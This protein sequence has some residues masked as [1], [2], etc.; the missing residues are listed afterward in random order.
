MNHIYKVVFC[1]TTGTF[2]AVA[3]YARAHGKKGSGSV[4]SASSASD[5][6]A[7]TGKY[8]MFSA[9]SSAML[10]LSGNVLAAT[11]TQTST[12]TA[13]TPP[14]TGTNAC[15]YEVS[16][17]A[18]VCGDVNTT[19]TATNGSNTI[20]L[21]TSASSSNTNDIAI[22][23]GAGKNF[24]DQGTNYGGTGNFTF[25]SNGVTQPN[26][27]SPSFATNTNVSIGS[28][29][30]TN[31][32]GQ[33]NVAIGNNASNQYYG[34][35]SIT[36]GTNANN[37]S[38][39]GMADGSGIAAGSVVRARRTV[40][41]GVNA[42]TY[43]EDSIA[44]GNA[45]KTVGVDSIA[46]GRGAKA[47]ITYPSTST[48][49]EQGAIA[50]G[51]GSNAPHNQDISIGQGAGNSIAQNYTGTQ[52]LAQNINIGQGSGDGSFTND[53][54]V[55]GNSSGRNVGRS[56]KRQQDNAV[57]GSGS[58]NNV[59]GDTNTVIGWQSGNNIGSNSNVGIGPRAGNNI[60]GAN[61]VAM[62][63][64]SGNFVSGG[65]NISLGAGSGNY[66]GVNDNATSY[67][68]TTNTFG[69]TGVR[70]TESNG[71]IAAGNSA[72]R[73]V[74][75]SSNFAFGETAGNYVNYDPSTKALTSK[76]GNMA[77]GQNAGSYINGSNNI[78]MG[79]N[80]GKGTASTAGVLVRDSS[81]NFGTSA[82]A[83]SNDS[84][85]MGTNSIAGVLNTTS[86]KNGIAIGNG[87]QAIGNQAISIGTG[88]VVR[89]TNSGAIGD[90]TTIDATGVTGSAVDG[91]YSIG[92]N[93]YIN[94][95]NTFILGNNVNK[96]GTNNLP[97][98]ANSVYLGNGSNVKD[99]TSVGQVI[100]STTALNNNTST[101]TAGTTTTGGANGSVS[102]AT[103]NSGNTSVTYGTFAG[104]LSNG[105]VS[106]GAAGTERRIQNVAAGQIAANSTDAING[107]Q[108]YAV[109]QKSTDNANQV[110][111]TY[112]H[113]GEG[114]GGGDAISNLGAITDAAGATGSDSVA[115]GKQAKASARATVAVGYGANAAQDYALANGYGAQAAGLASTAIGAF[116]SATELGSIA[117]G[118]SSSATAENA[119]ALGRSSNA[120]IA[121]SVALGSDSVT[122]DPV[123]TSS[124]T[125]NGI[126]Y[127]G[128]AGSTP[129]SVVSIG[130]AGTER[131]LQNVAA[132]QI[133]ATSTDAI[134]G[135][136]LYMT[137]NVVGN[138]ASSTA[139][140]LGGNAAVDNAGNITMTD[141]G[142]TGKN[143]V[144]DAI[145]ANTAQINNTYFH[146]NT[147]GYNSINGTT[148]GGNVGT[149]NATTNLGAITDAA[150]ATQGGAVTAGINA[151]ATSAFGVAIGN[152]TNADGTGGNTNNG[153][154]IA[155]GNGA[156]ATGDVA[157][158]A[159]GV[160]A[161]ANGHQATA[162]GLQSNAVGSFTTAFG[163]NSN[164]NNYNA[165]AIGNYTAATG[166]DSAS[167]GSN[168]T[169]SG[170]YSTTTGNYAQA[171]GTLASA[172][173]HSA[174][175]Q[176]D[177]STATGANAQAVNAYDT[178]VG[179]NAT[180][181]GGNSTAVGNSAS[182]SGA[183][184][185]ALGSNA[186]A[187]G[188]SSNAIGNAASANADNSIAMGSSAYTGIDNAIAIGNNASAYNADGDVALGSNSTTSAVVPTTNGI[189]N[190]ITYGDFAGNAP[191][192]AVSIG[193]AG[194]ERQLQNVAAGQISATS[195]DAINGSQLYMTQ[196][197]V[198]NVANST[199]SILGGNAVVDPN[200]GNI[201][202]S[203][204]GG[205]GKDNVNDA[206]AAAR[207]T[208]QSSDNSINVTA[209]TGAAGNLAYDIKVNNQAIVEGAQ[210]PVVYTDTSGNKVIKSPNGNFYPA[211]TP[212][213]TN[214]NP[215]NGAAPVT[216]V[217]ASMN[218]PNNS[219]NTPTTLANVAGNLNG[220]APNTTAPTTVGT[221]PPTVN[222][223][224]AATVG[225]VLNAGWNLKTAD[226]G[227][228]DFV[229]PYD[230]VEFKNGTGTKVRS[231][232]TNGTANEIQF[233]INTSALNQNTD[234]SVT[235]GTTGDT[236]ATAE[237]VANAINNSGFNLTAQGEN[238]SLVKPGST[239]DMNNTDGNILITKSGANNNVTYNLA[240]TI[241]VGTTNPVTING[242]AGTVNGLTNTTFDPNNYVTGQAATEDQIA[243][244]VKNIDN[245]NTGTVTKG[246]NFNTDSNSQI[247]KDL[248]DELKI[249]GD[250]KNITTKT[251]NGNVVVSMTD[252]PKFTSVTTGNTVISDSG[253]TINNTDPSKVVSLTN[254][255]LNNGNNKIVNVANGDISNTS[256]DAVNGS[257]LYATNQ[258]IDTITNNITETIN[259]GTVYSGDTTTGATNAFTRQLGEQTNIVGGA[260]G[261]LTD[262]NIG[263]VSNGIDTLTVKLAKDINLGTD[264][265]V[266]ITNSDPTKTVSLTNTGLNNGG[267]IISNVG[268]GGTTT[269]NAANIGDVQNARTT[270]KSSDNSISVV[271]TA[272]AGSPNLS[273]DIK[274]NNQGITNGAQL[275]VVYTNTNGDKVYITGTDA[276]N[277]PIFNTKS[278][279]TGTAV[280]PAN[281]IASMQNA[282]GS[283]TNATTLTNVAPAALNQTSKD[284]VNGSQL[285][286]TNQQVANNTQNI[287]TNTQNIAANTANIAKGI[288]FGGTT[289]SN[290]YQLGDTI[291]VKG[292]SNIISTTVAGGAQLSLARDITVN[293]VTAGNTVLS[294]TGL[295]NG[296]NTIT[297]VA[298]GVNSTDAVNVG[299]LNNVKNVIGMVDGQTAPNIKVYNV[300]ERGTK[301]NVTV[302]DAINHMN[303]E[304]IQYFHTNGSNTN[305]IRG[306]GN[307]Q[308]SSAEGARS[309]AI[310]VKASVG[311]DASD[312]LA[313]GA[314][315]TV[316]DKAANAVA[317]GSGSVAKQTPA[318]LQAT[319][320][321]IPRG[322]RNGA[323]A[324]TGKDV[325]GEV[326]VG[327]TEATR[328]IT[329]LAAGAMPTDAVN[330]SQ[331]AAVDDKVNRLGYKVNDVADEA[332]AGISSAMAMAALPQAYLP[333]KSMLAGGMA[334]YNGEG[335]VAI[336]VSKLSDNGRWVIKVNGTADTKGNAG[337]AVGAG[338]HW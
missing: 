311:K 51:Q 256:T 157:P 60:N 334:T 192:S 89:A 39:N 252:T 139:K 254:A 53:N 182:A 277:N 27:A 106:V 24:K 179:N 130:A 219:T 102:S 84:I 226:K 227:D 207:T 243:Q 13:V 164:A 175:A 14:A 75:G 176:S 76:N 50:I 159:I 15:Y 25:Y 293:S 8:L 95:S 153:G 112:F 140:V 315:A 96:N 45:A 308:D 330:V 305:A 30:G 322:T 168:A 236:F 323:I 33:R 199:A 262:N 48:N 42:M 215:T 324:G 301:D 142:G 283:T 303:T 211:G 162:V 248:G 300:A 333:G 251:E 126:T 287:A 122:T 302:V 209:N 278:D 97:S 149:G 286:A 12:G 288:N 81:L 173:G 250:G 291:N 265:S 66:V 152:N 313:L 134:N 186:S 241:K 231:Q 52:P 212:L 220:A 307:T 151:Q 65:A 119:M 107:S 91:S 29:A 253:V 150:G 138:V 312:S 206:I 59:Q 216:N 181:Q 177:Y 46:I 306:E 245:T 289:G 120:N 298:A 268:S 44:L 64:Q 188:A 190:G 105:A 57:L 221:L 43:G 18:V 111:N 83:Y 68:A 148:T 92:N 269:T 321:Y 170:D 234:G 116:S 80:A 331:L 246:L 40:A 26:T 62:V 20:A 272:A 282:T 85:A 5:S 74:A 79:A 17:G 41:I 11:G 208:V 338:F 87:A 318:Q 156:R 129:T 55:V 296:G 49:T 69:G 284:A 169:A 127:S 78:T 240:P 1:K 163:A 222:Q 88:N 309:T 187:N 158:L 314:N 110:N 281:V 118:V 93:N 264:G 271:N 225:D 7:K 292:D 123:A 266:T 276:N 320:A 32:T 228:L 224:N 137:Q 100:T 3:E 259:K 197:V 299:Q 117:T 230:T 94:S 31:S 19:T 141:V 275:P 233:D 171:S 133:S 273:Y 63:I 178:A 16:S 258:K 294:T 147:G 21:G 202:M 261:T 28:G 244:V 36:L 145:A 6:V 90:P 214:G 295:N 329:N 172:F 310:G 332:N 280:Q 337:A 155:I 56:T 4:G 77:F 218:N 184:S 167:I 297:N 260:T 198:G 201:T 229:R 204:I 255:G 143:N 183:I 238:T 113:I 115:A 304:G 242:N 61:N 267:N 166:N 191:T 232:N 54:V 135:S 239:V 210:L 34:E 9:I 217:I 128:F 146:T 132:G 189:V 279:G 124:G 249:L 335:A 114:Q 121:N 71:N 180:A 98:I 82:T 270:V 223:N 165:L 67:D 319:P 108:L 325:I 235:A 326:S 161:N 213:D 104:A 22:G 193:A 327:D 317:L 185:N 37:I 99:S 237:S 72:G 23:N 285:Y 47:I 200:T 194:T 2:V 174:N 247:H 205:T 103:L 195:T 160:S 136:Q 203:D 316:A 58:G 101:G 274:V 257:Q 328:R 86:V 336:G 70:Q 196:N 10:L 109:A 35:D 144:N 73:Y 290:N 38:A 263:V 154:S 125:V 131:Q